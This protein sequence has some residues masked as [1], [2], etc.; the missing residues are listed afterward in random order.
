MVISFWISLV[1]VYCLGR[2][3]IITPVINEKLGVTVFH[4]TY[5]CYFTPLITG[6]P[7]VR[8]VRVPLDPV[9]SGLDPGIG[10]CHFR[11]GT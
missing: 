4:P 2:C 11:E 8:V 5:R 1:I 9:I 7:L 10:S 6:R 3:H